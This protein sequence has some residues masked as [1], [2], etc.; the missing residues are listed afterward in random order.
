[1]QLKM[2][3]TKKMAD[4][5]GEVTGR[6]EE[7]QQ[8]GSTSSGY[9][10]D[11]EASYLKANQK[12]GDSTQ[13]KRRKLEFRPPR[14]GPT[15]GLSSSSS[16]EIALQRRQRKMNAHDWDSSYEPFSVDVKYTALEKLRAPGDFAIESDPN[17][18]PCCGKPK[19]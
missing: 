3:Q 10:A 16:D 19:I 8:K 5:G 13:L 12:G 9:E 17:N 15:K 4:R 11:D 7:K 1:M 2:D 6:K 18:Q 14:D